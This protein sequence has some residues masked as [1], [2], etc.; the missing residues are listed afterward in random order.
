MG[1]ND[2]LGVGLD[3]ITQQGEQSDLALGRKGNFRFVH[4][5]EPIAGDPLG[6]DVEE[7]LAVGA[8]IEIAITGDQC[9]ALAFESSAHGIRVRRFR[10]DR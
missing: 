3:G 10:P 8:G 7:T 6:E 2:E 5:I 4:Q 9:I 1:G